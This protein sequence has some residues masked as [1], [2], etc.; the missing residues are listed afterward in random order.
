MTMWKILEVNEVYGRTTGGIDTNGL[1]Q[2][3]PCGLLKVFDLAIN[4]GLNVSLMP[5]ILGVLDLR[6]TR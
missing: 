3:L 1:E 2:G 4:I 6:S 5:A